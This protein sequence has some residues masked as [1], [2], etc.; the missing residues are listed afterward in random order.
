MIGF[1]VRPSPQARAL[2]ESSGVEVRLYQIIYK[3]VEEVEAAL[4]GMLKPVFT[5]VVTARA[6][7]RAV[8]KVP[9]LGKVAGSY[10]EDG[11]VTRGSKVRLVRDGIVVADSTV[12]SLRRFKDDVREVQQG[13]ECGIGIED[14]Q[15][16]K[17]GDVLE[18]YE[19]REIPRD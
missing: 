4:K 19:V 2:A 16:I 10:V 11:T 12:S 8:F 9:K 13:F 1:N 17:E 5:E 6:E 3:L 18:C 7:V 14:Y 15:D